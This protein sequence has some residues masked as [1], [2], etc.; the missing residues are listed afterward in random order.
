MAGAYTTTNRGAGQRPNAG[1]TRLHPDD[2]VFI[3]PDEWAT[4]LAGTFEISEDQAGAILS[5]IA[6]GDASGSGL[7][8]L[9]RLWE[10]AL[11]ECAQF[12]MDRDVAVGMDL[13]YFRWFHP[14]G[15]RRVLNGTELAS[16]VGVWQ[17]ARDL[18]AGIASL[19]VLSVDDD[20]D[21]DTQTEGIT[22]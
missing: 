4:V 2:Y 14:P 22:H 1:A 12:V 13:G 8:A 18:D 9:D 17:V 16:T 21:T 6:D 11:N 5:M 7:P 20:V 10:R 19:E 3:R 15:G